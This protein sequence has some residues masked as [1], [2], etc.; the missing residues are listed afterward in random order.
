MH[1]LGSHYLGRIFSTKEDIYK[2]VG[3]ILLTVQQASMPLMVRSTRYRKEND[4]F[5][6]TVN[7]FIMEVVKLT[8]CSAILIGKDKSIT[9]FIN[10][11][12]TA[13]FEDIGE[14]L[15]IC[16][17]SIIYILQNN[18]YYIALTNL[19]ATTFCP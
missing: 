17:P 14:T 11:L 8:V 19:E 7:V 13:I 5:I 16:I 6:T 10:S 18:L 4:V 9:K 3:I 12:K 1:Q 2:Y 15:K